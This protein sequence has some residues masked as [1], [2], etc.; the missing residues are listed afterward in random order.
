MERERDRDGQVLV[1]GA[2]V[3]VAGG[4]HVG[5]GIGVAHVGLGH[6]VVGLQATKLCATRNRAAPASRK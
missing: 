1:P 5:L 6:H 4:A 2:V 3:L